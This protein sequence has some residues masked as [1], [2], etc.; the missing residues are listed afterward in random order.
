MSPAQKDELIGAL[1]LMVGPLQERVKA[2]EGRLMLNSGNS[3]KPPSSDGLVK[4][5]PKSLRLKGQRPVGGQ[6]G[7]EG[8]TL[9]QSARV[10]EVIAHWGGAA[11]PGLPGP[12]AGARSD[13]QTPGL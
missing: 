10:D 5:A 7:H 6:K 4:P 11:L 8:N 9:R 3:S 12:M 1:W 2:L 13:R